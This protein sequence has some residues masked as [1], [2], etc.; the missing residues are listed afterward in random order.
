MSTPLARATT[1]ALVPVE[2]IGNDAITN[3]EDRAVRITT[4]GGH[5]ID[6][7]TITDVLAIA[8]RQL[9]SCADDNYISPSVS[10]RRC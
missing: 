4:K 3:V 10:D 6:G 9:H 2:I 1:P 7:L 5:Q 8:Q